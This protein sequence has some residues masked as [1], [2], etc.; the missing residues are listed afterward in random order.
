VSAPTR[1][2]STGKRSPKAAAKPPRDEQAADDAI[3]QAEA[4]IAELGQMPEDVSPIG[5]NGEIRPVVI[6]KKGKKG[7]E[8]VHIFTLDEVEYSVPKKIGVA[9]TIAFQEDLR[10]VG[11]EA[12]VWRLM[13]NMLGQK[14]LDALASSPDTDEEDVAKVMTIVATLAFG[15]MKQLQE[16][17]DPS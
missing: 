5:P 10:K 4:A 14:A 16:A 9:R 8:L 7:P 1:R 2:R 11:R 13:K 12:A 6:G 3:A 17:T 15:S